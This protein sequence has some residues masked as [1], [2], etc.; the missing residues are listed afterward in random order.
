MYC[1]WC[2][3]QAGSWTWAFWI[4]VLLLVALVVLAVVLVMVLRPWAKG[5]TSDAAHGGYHD[6]G[7]GALRILDERFARGEIDEEEYARR[8]SLLLGSAGKA[9]SESA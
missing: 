4:L 7:E 3:M 5:G 8:R 9:S 1:P 2:G 6:S